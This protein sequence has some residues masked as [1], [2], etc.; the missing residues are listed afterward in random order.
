MALR[1]LSLCSGIG[2]LDLGVKR[3]L[4]DGVR[5]VCYVEREAYAA[6]VLVARMA[7]SA[8]DAAPVWDDLDTFDA[9]AWRGA[10][11]IVVAGF[12]CQP[13]SVAGSRLGTEDER[14]LWPRIAEI[15]GDVGPRYAFLENVPGLV[16]GRGLGA[17]LG[18]LA[19][20][21]F[22]AEWTTLRASDVGAPHRRERLFI[23]AHG[24]RVG[25]DGIQPLTVTGVR[26]PPRA[27]G[28]GGSMADATDIGL[29]GGRERSG[30]AVIAYARE[31]GTG[32]TLPESGRDMGDPHL[33]RLQGRERPHGQGPDELPAW[34]PGPEE[35]DRWAGILARWPELAPAVGNAVR[36]RRAGP[37]DAIRRLGADAGAGPAGEPGGG[38]EAESGLRG[39]ADGSA[40]RVDRLRALGNAVVPAQAERAL[41]LLLDRLG[42]G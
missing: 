38:G 22:D 7:E 23:L 18:G 41:R 24:R 30:S 8:L 26:V 39:V 11:D 33:P 5:T 36:G 25:T 28:N 27:R 15:I 12:P 10:V 13:W 40:Y 32:A 3:A 19:D 34:P 4:G 1:A 6:A 35:R 17:V 9:R 16:N 20:L 29:N 21:G 2:G 31:L 37:R 14:W 42:G